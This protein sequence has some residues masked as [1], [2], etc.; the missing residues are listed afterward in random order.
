[1]KKQASTKQTKARPNEKTAESAEN[2]S[3]M[4]RNLNICNAVPAISSQVVSNEKVASAVHASSFVRPRELVSFV[5]PMELLGFVRPRGLVSF[6]RPRELLSFARPRELLSFVRP[7]E[8]LS[9]ARPMELVSFFRARELVSFARPRELL[10]LAHPREL[11]SFDPRHVTR[12]P[13]IRKRC[14]LS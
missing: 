6:V 13:P 9:F 12:F 3:A 7:R 1:M 2:I 5:R 10:G 14:C 8:L 4:K 11:L